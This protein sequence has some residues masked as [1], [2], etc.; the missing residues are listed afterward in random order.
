MPIIS[1][2][3]IRLSYEDIGQG[4]PVVMVMGTGVRGR[5]W[6]LH[7]VPAFNAAGYRAITVDNR[8]IP[9]SDVCAEGFTIHDMVGDLVGLVE[10]LNVGPCR[11]VG[12]SMGAYAVQELALVRPDLVRQAVLIATRGRSDAL[13][14]A[15]SL[16]EIELARTESVVPAR[17]RAVVRAM[18]NLSPRTLDD[19]IKAKD[20]LEIFELSSGAAEPGVNAQLGLE[21]IPNRL[22]A[23]QDIRAPCQVIAFEDDLITPPH[24]GRELA[25]TIPTAS[26]ELIQGAG[27]YGYLEEPEAVNKC[28]LAFFGQ[29]G[30]DGNSERR[31]P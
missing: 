20:W 13:R 18:Q 24:L 26:F 21:P 9:P 3:G 6:H 23:Y 4:D 2:N 30:T 8:G 25:E 31:E 1:V 7:Q 27:H 28:V 16:A 19:E 22:G 29:P 14:T 17:Y 5:A 12:T 10:H 11:F 15:L